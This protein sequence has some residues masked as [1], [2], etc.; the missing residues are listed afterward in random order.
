MTWR[1]G[2]LS[3]CLSNRAVSSGV[4]HAPDTAAVFR[5][6]RRKKKKDALP[7]K[8]YERYLRAILSSYLTGQALRCCLPGQRSACLSTS[9]DQARKG[10][11]GRCAKASGGS[12]KR[13]STIG[14]EHV[15]SL[16]A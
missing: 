8:G 9:S 5:G 6:R 4:G 1:P 12:S 10:K 7:Q 13:S 15:G 11:M 14:R 2:S 16:M 3:P